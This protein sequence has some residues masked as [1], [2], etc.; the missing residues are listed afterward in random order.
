MAKILIG[1]ES[2]GGFGH[3][4]RIRLVA[5]ELKARGHEP[6]LA[7]R[8]VVEPAPMLAG[9]PY[10]V[11]Q[12]PHWA[13]GTPQR[14]SP[15]SAATFADILAVIGFADA[16]DLSANLRAWDALF[17][18]VRPDLVLAEYAPMMVLAARGRFPTVL[19]G[20]G[21]TV[22]PADLA[23]YPRL[24]S[25]VKISMPEAEVLAVVQEAQ[26]RRGGPVPQRLSEIFACDYRFPCTFPELD[27]YRPLRRE[28]VIP[29]LSDLPPP[30]PPPAEPR[31]FA[32]LAAEAPGLPRFVLG[33]VKSGVPGGIFL[34]RPAQDFKDALKKTR[35]TL[36]EEPQPLAEVL[37][38]AKFVI[39]HGGAG[40][41]EAC[42][43]SGRPQVIFPRHLEQT[44]TARS[45]R[46]LGAAIMVKRDM[47]EELVA[48]AVREFADNAAALDRATALSHEI[49]ARGPRPGVAPIVAACEA[50]LSRPRAAVS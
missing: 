50:L 17:S 26:K 32:Y 16:D 19:F 34:R 48:K 43:T 3:V 12:G 1:W 7:L 20:S 38:N 45:L 9:E 23:L 29:P 39:H 2:G 14:F 44:M 6:I 30:S 13:R 11:L 35:L 42:L 25:R 40:T 10:P 47:N 22:P 24:Q 5:R 49:A 28:P 41:S 36:Y 33:L 31:F 15:F 27:P 37:A 46:A 18:V 4:A 21:F 8:D